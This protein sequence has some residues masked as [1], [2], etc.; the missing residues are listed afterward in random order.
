MA[1]QIDYPR[2]SLKNSL[3]LAVAVDAL[4]GSC[5]SEMAA[6]RMGKRGGGAF[7]ALI[8][9]SVRYKLLTN[10]KGQ[11]ATTNHFKAFKLA[12]TDDEERE[13]LM[14]S[15][16]APPLFSAVANRFHGRE[17]P[18]NHFEKLLIKEFGVSE[19]ISSRVAKYFIEGAKQCGVLDSN[20][21]V[22]NSGDSGDL[23][24][25]DQIDKENDASE[26]VDTN[27]GNGAHEQTSQLPEQAPEK[28]SIRIIGPG[29]DSTIIINE[30]EDLFIVNAM[31]KKV[32]RKLASGEKDKSTDGE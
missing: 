29:M 3:Q 28:F 21:V 20:G 19:Q 17:L 24:K 22:S 30:E 4:G 16:L 6:E 15:F 7:Q 10:A 12:Y 31:L 9:S 5:S 1:K 23:P 13:V 26:P 11:L 14:K 25:D 27:T 8:S 2:A 18:T 32:Q